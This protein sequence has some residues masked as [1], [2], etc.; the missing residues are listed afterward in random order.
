MFVEFVDN[1]VFTGKYIT[2]FFVV[3]KYGID[4]FLGQPPRT[5]QQHIDNK[6]MSTLS[7]KGIGINHV[8][9]SRTVAR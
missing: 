2:L 5:F 6:I 8:R 1:E 3:S 7:Q 4:F 9:P